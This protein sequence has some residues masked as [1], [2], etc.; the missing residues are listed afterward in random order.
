MTFLELK[1]WLARLTL[2]AVLLVTA[3]ALIVH[4]SW[5]RAVLEQWLRAAGPAAPVVGVGLMLVQTLVSPIP[6]AVVVMAIGAVF[7]PWWGA[8]IS[9]VGAILGATLAYWLAFAGLKAHF[10]RVRQLGFL[11][12]L[13]IRLVPGVSV[14]LIS[15]G[16][17]AAHVPFP[18]FLFSTLFGLIPRTL[19][20]SLFGHELW[21]NPRQGLLLLGVLMPMIG[22]IAYAFSRS[23]NLSKIFST[24]SAH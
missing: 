7:G 1:K 4:V 21:D 16:C 24:E 13:G 20:F 23:E 8:L 12:L 14:D 17:G 22:L 9:W 5:E 18:T 2:V 6:F 15:Y 11:A 19:A 3:Y 10:P